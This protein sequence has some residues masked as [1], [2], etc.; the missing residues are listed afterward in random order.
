MLSE[1]GTVDRFGQGLIS[2]HEEFV[3]GG[4]FVP[5]DGSVAADYF[6]NHHLSFVAHYATDPQVTQWFA[7]HIMRAAY[8]HFIPVGTTQVVVAFA[9]SS[10]S[11]SSSFSC[12]AAIY[13]HSGKKV[14]SRTRQNDGFSPFPDPD[15]VAVNTTA[16]PARIRFQEDLVNIC[17]TA[18]VLYYR[19]DFPRSATTRRVTNVTG[20]AAAVSDP[21]VGTIV[22][23]AGTYHLT[24]STTAMCANAFSHLAGMDDVFHYIV[25]GDGRDK[26]GVTTTPLENPERYSGVK[27]RRFVSALC[28]NRHLSIRAETN[29]TVVLDAMKQTWRVLYV[30]NGA[31]AELVGLHITG[32]KADEGGG[33]VFISSG[34]QAILTSCAITG[35]DGS[36]RGGGLQVW[37]GGQATLTS[38]TISENMASW[39]G[40]LASSAGS[41]LTMIE[42]IISGNNA[43]MGYGGGGLGISGQ[44]SLTSCTISGN[45]GAEAGGVL[46]D[47]TATL[48]SCTIS[49]NVADHLL[50]NAGKQFGGAGGL[51]ITKPLSADPRQVGK[52]TLT[53][54]TISGNEAINHY[55]AGLA[56]VLGADLTLI[57]CVISGNKASHGGGLYLD[58][59]ATLSSCTIAG[60]SAIQGGGLLIGAQSS[61]TLLSSTVS[62]NDADWTGGGL[63]LEAGGVALITGDSV[64]V[65]NR[66]PAGSSV[67]NQANAAVYQ[68]PTPPGTYLPDE[69]TC[70]SSCAGFPRAEQRANLSLIEDVDLPYTC[71][72]GYWCDGVERHPCPAGKRGDGTGFSNS[73]CGGDCPEGRY[74]PENSTTPLICPDG[75]FSEAGTGQSS[76]PEC[77]PGKWCVGGQ[78]YDCPAATFG[79]SPRQDRIQSCSPCPFNTTTLSNGASDPSECVCQ[80]DFFDDLSR[81]PSDVTG[82]RTCTSCPPG[83][84]CSEGAATTHNVTVASGFWR[85]SINAIKAKPCPIDGTCAGGNGSQLCNRGF[86]GVYCKSCADPG[87]FL[88]MLKSECRSCHSE[89]AML[90]KWLLGVLGTLLGVLVLTFGFRLVSKHRSRRQPLLLQEPLQLQEEPGRR[91]NPSIELMIRVPPATRTMARL[92]AAAQTIR[93]P[94]GKVVPRLKAAAEIMGLRSKLK[95]CLGFYVIL[96]QVEN[97]YQIRY[98]SDYQSISNFVFAPLRRDLLAWLPG[99]HL[100]CLGA[101]SIFAKLVVYLSFPAAVVVLALVISHAASLCGHAPDRHSLL[102]ALPFVLFWTSFVFPSVSSIGFQAVSVCDCFDELTGGSNTRRCFLP[103]DYSYECPTE[104][105]GPEVLILGTA[106]IVIYGIGVPV[107]FA[108]LLYTARKGIRAQKEKLRTDSQPG[109]LVAALSFLHGNLIS[110]ALW[111]PL[112]DA[113]RALVLAG[114]LALVA[115]GE[116]IQ[117]LCGV[118]VAL[119]YLVLQI[120]MS[121]YR[122]RSDNLLA[123]GAGL[124]LVL[125]LLSSFGLQLNALTSQAFISPIVL[126][127][128][129]YAAGVATFGSTMVIFLV[130]VRKQLSRRKPLLIYHCSPSVAPLPNVQPE[131]VEVKRAYC[132]DAE[133]FSGT[134]ELLRKK[135][136]D[137]RPARFL[138]AGHADRQLDPG[139][140]TLAFEDDT[141]RLPELVRPDTLVDMFLS[142]R[143]RR[144]EMLE[145]V[146]LNGCE[147]EDLGRALREQAKVPWIVCWRTKCDDEAARLFSVHFF[148]ALSRAGALETEPYPSAFYEAK[149]ALITKHTRAGTSAD[150]TAAQVPKFVFRAIQGRLPTSAERGNLAEL[151]DSL[152]DEEPGESA[153]QAAQQAG[154]V[155]EST[156]SAR[157]VGVPLLLCP[158]GEVLVGE[159]PA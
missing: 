21:S 72:R 132:D 29:G 117:I 35:N 27:S 151:P 80:P 49:G 74:C 140:R 134:S 31:R 152:E 96:A 116:P 17:W 7:N 19:P 108:R 18:Y 57:S 89:Q 159:D 125:N 147:S 61:M 71:P 23:A 155:R 20:L 133:V 144:G 24:N 112:V 64:F 105:A 75:T 56:A 157:E 9:G 145:L 87:H 149:S 131:A 5:S 50:V 82:A 69:W 70:D 148:E 47:G 94:A 114:I 126:S 118:M 86:D 110:D 45:H 48:T 93:P 4:W 84:D 120:W 100:E 43:R 2:S 77:L 122:M 153:H 62:H 141:G 111:W 113:S 99:L 103:A 150:G 44:A 14:Y 78:Q 55:G 158:N 101:S 102:P 32:G 33:G 63:H 142:L 136:L 85:P 26:P 42:C 6:N 124:S 40:G 11:G 28:I 41:Q 119:F 121:P 58:G 156:S 83:F 88:D 92:S 8:E 22:V 10:A 53:L 154:Q 60:N 79:E 59:K 3:A 13:D 37:T 65:S 138:F 135:L 97:V 107:L 66:A 16:G 76:C 106:A 127:I 104:H 46:I 52:A 143:E 73:Q 38:C 54:C 95:I 36:V 137:E 91:H 81:K 109:H 12:T 90:G 34:G 129:L 98:P 123:L 39:G 15:V 67:A 25:G 146:F 68:L 51:K 128:V 1:W 139:K 115:P 130:A 30:G